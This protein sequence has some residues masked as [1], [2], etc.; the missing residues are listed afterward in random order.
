MKKCRLCDI[1]NIVSDICKIE[2]DAAMQIILETDIGRAILNNN[3]D[4][5]YEQITDNVYSVSRELKPDYIRYK[6]LITPQAIRAA[7]LGHERHSMTKKTTYQRSSKLLK[8]QKQKIKSL[9]QK[10]FASK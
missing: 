9:R 10:Q 6:K 1:S 4:V 3:P 5:L 8:A 7:Y 2:Y